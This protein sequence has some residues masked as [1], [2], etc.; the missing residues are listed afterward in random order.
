MKNTNTLRMRSD[1]ARKLALATKAL[2][3]IG[4]TIFQVG[5]LATASC[6]AD[7]CADPDLWEEGATLDEVAEAWSEDARQTTSSTLVPS[8]WHQTIADDVFDAGAFLL[9]PGEDEG[10]AE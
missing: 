3:A 7:E 9:A 4:L 2:A 10:A 8:C 5:A 1:A 6:I